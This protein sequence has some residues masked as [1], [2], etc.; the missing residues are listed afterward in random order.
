MKKFVSASLVAGLIAAA[1]ALA[2]SA[3]AADPYQGSVFTTTS[4]NSIV[5]SAG[6]AADITGMVSSGGAKVAARKADN[7][8]GT[9]RVTVKLVRDGKLMQKVTKFRRIS[10]GKSFRVNTV[11][12]LRFSG[13]YTVRAVFRPDRGS[14][15]QRSVGTGTVRV[16]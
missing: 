1:G 2:P 13:T 8:D 4:V 3:H 9:L 5:S 11:K 6:D 16:S 10:V 7:N 15:F 14:T 12:K